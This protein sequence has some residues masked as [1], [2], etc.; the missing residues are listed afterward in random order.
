M[1]LELKISATEEKNSIY[2]YDCTGNYS[3][4][5][6]G[7]WGIQNSKIE[8]VI[9]AF[10]E[11]RPPGLKKSDPP[12]LITVFPN[13]PNKEGNPY[14]V[15]PHVF[16]KNEIESGE[17]KIK[18]TTVTED[19]VNGKKTHTAFYSLFCLKSVTCCI[20]K[21]MMQVRSGGFKDEKQKLILELS[22]LLT[23]VTYQVD[24]GNYDTASE[25]T[26]Y[27]KAQCSCCGCS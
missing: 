8:S 5:N 25:D 20:D 9:E 7:G 11:V 17:Y 14:E 21:K 1:G 13:I 10:Y 15:L 6:K 19:K 26:E 22:S 2:L 4:E 18:L 12:V 16:G 23:A 27:L 24:C 3:F